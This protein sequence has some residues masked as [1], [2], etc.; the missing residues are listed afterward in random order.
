VIHIS[1]CG[2]YVRHRR[3][4]YIF[5]KDDKQEREYT[6]HKQDKV[7]TLQSA[8]ALHIENHFK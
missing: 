8:D 3:Y 2:R 1:V 5:D 4:K 7:K 6:T